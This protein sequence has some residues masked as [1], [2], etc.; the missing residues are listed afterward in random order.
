MINHI[1]IS[2]FAIIENT[3]VEFKDGLNIITGETG[4]GKSIVID[5]ISLALGRRADSSCIRTGCDKAKVQL[6]GEL[7]GE[8]IVISREVS[9]SGKN[10]CKLNGEI[11]PLSKLNEFT[12]K[13]ADIHGQYDNQSL[14]NPDYHIE[15]IDLYRSDEISPL[16]ARV[17]S[18]YETFSGVKSSLIKLLN[19]AKENER[20][21]D[22][23]R[24]EIDEIDKADLRIGED[25]E[26]SETIALLQ[27]S[28]RIFA[29]IEKAFAALGEEGAV[30]DLMSAAKPSLDGLS[31]FSRELSSISDEYSDIYYRLDELS[32][33]LE[34]I[35][36]GISF[37]PIE[38]DNAIT[39]LNLIDNLKK[40]Y[41]GTIESALSYREDICN[42]LKVIDNFDEEELRLKKNLLDAKN[43]LSLSCAALTEKRKEIAG[44]LKE[45]IL[46]ELKDLNFPD[47]RLDIDISPLERPAENGADK[48][49][50]LIS[51]NKGEPPKPLYKVASGGEMSRI[52][53]AFKK[54]ISTYDMIPT[55]IFDE[56]DNGIS[57]ITASIVAKKLKEISSKHQ[58]ICI[59]H[60]PQ[61]AASGKHNYRIFKE[62]DDT[63]TYTK[64]L[65]LTESEKTEEIAGLLGGSNVTETTLR[66]AK[67]LIASSEG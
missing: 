9:S 54:I 59:T 41:G 57:G 34:K 10:L 44:E 43:K 60:L 24:F 1:S 38:L 42:K 64:I 51:A 30:L 58:I 62:S 7:T 28:E 18:D 48:V 26:L 45:K 6:T 3:E 5:A 39:R 20:K 27:N 23:Y 4:S 55:L 12:S 8:E 17:K 52:M 2:N 14:L 21:Q 15:L 31:P 65:P 32:G 36:D 22:F 49:E 63:A 56:I 29:G 66:S 13:L 16:K 67:E 25:D 11:V 50:I 53:L 37:S 33:R 19:E 47:A 40:K 35:R 46:S 61:I